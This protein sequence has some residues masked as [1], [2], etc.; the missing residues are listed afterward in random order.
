M[1]DEFITDEQI[2]LLYSSVCEHMFCKLCH[3]YIFIVPANC[4]RWIEYDEHDIDECCSDEHPD[5]EGL[6]AGVS[7]H[8]KPRGNI[9]AKQ[10][11][12]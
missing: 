10:G 8:R 4:D 5:S 9:G 11:R 6:P 2:D 1:L 7:K 12:I 3:K